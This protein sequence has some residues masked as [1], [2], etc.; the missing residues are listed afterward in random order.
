MRSTL[1]SGCVAMAASAVPKMTKTKTSAA[2][3]AAPKKSVRAAYAL[4][5]FSPLYPW[6][7]VYLGRD[8]QALVFATSANGFML[9]WLL[10]AACIPWY[11]SVANGTDDA[12]VTRARVEDWRSLGGLLGPARSLVATAVGFAWSYAA[13][14][15][16]A[17]RHAAF[18]TA[19]GVAFLRVALGALGAAAGAALA[20]GT[21]F[22]CRAAASPRAA[23]RGAS[24]MAAFALAAP[25]SRAALRAGDSGAVCFFLGLTA[26]L[27]A[28]ASRALVD[29][30]AVERTPRR[31]YRVPGHVLLVA[32]CWLAFASNASGPGRGLRRGARLGYDCVFGGDD[33]AC[34]KRARQAARMHDDARVSRARRALGLGTNATFEE[35]RAA[36]KRLALKYHP[37][38][39]GDPRNRDKFEAV[40]AAYEVLKEKKRDTAPPAAADETR[41]KPKYK[42]KTAAGADAAAPP[43]PRESPP[44]ADAPR[45]KK[46]K[47]K[48]RRKNPP[49]DL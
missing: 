13:S 8:A 6:Y 16:V 5:A 39:S 40:E 9:G 35:A 43:P 7:L 23:F 28:R 48:K 33:L 37:D 24:T 22:L 18:L 1:N 44:D 49:A 11:V 41:P 34:A 15:L 25:S 46:N 32:L 2:A 3:A 4:W 45:E 27:G 29:R 17:N 38:K 20:S 47:K 30:P 21:V 26:V 36:R 14:H 10:D 19:E 42:R 12:D 31:R